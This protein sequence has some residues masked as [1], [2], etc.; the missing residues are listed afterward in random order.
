MKKII[1]S[2]DPGKENF[3]VSIQQI[4][5]DGVKVINSFLLKNR[6]VDLKE[7]K[8]NSY[9]TLLT[10][11]VS[12]FESILDKYSPE[13]CSMERYQV[14]FRTFG[15]LAELVNIMIGVV[16]LICLKRKIRINLTIASSWKNKFNQKSEIPL[17]DLYKLVK[18]LPPHL[19]D[20]SLIGLHFNIED[21]ENLYKKE[22]LENYCLSLK[23]LFDESDK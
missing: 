16:S 20:A 19:I 18:K 9:M 5:E 3:A 2:A 1:L 14:R 10:N 21:K 8:K 22:F 13:E 23:R 7:D 11:F 6:I 17:D 15:N 12:E 4:D